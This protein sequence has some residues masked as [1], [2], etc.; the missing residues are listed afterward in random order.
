MIASICFDIPAVQRDF[1]IRGNTEKLENF[2]N[3]Y[4]IQVN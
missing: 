3:S 1:L 2:Y 4:L